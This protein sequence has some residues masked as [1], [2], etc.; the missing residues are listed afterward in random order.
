MSEQIGK[1]EQG[2]LQAMNAIDNQVARAMQRTPAQ[3]ETHGVQKWQPYAVRVEHIT[4]FL[5][6]EVGTNST[7]LDSIL[8]LS[9]AF[10]KAL[11][12]IV[13]DLGKSGLGE[14]RAEYCLDAMEKVS[15]D[16][17]EVMSALTEQPMV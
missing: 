10:T 13:S 5:L 11:Q 17:Q 7:T 9:Q 8:V 4:A 3:R 12:L 2:L 14:V 15:R 6:E 1:L 16:A